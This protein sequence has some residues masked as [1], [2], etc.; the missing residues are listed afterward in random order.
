[1]AV[2][3]RLKFAAM[4][5]EVARKRKGD[6]INADPHCKDAENSVDGVA[7]LPAT[8]WGR[9]LDFMPYTEVRSVLLVGKH[10]AVEAVKHVKTLNVMRG[11]ELYIPAARR[12]GNVEEVNIFCL[13]KERE[14]NDGNAPFSISQDVT[15]RAVPFFGGFSK[16]AR[17]FIGGLDSD[18][19]RRTYIP[20]TQDE[21]SEADFMR[22][23]EES[24]YRNLIFAYVGAIK[25]GALSRRIVFEGFNN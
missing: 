2:V 8:V 18:G 21:S 11:C 10:I 9:V 3:F 12:F 17:G 4:K 1:L 15:G 14:S 20:Y 19:T 16:L 6:Q 25:A 13:L 7:H 5:T 24:M 22:M 23:L